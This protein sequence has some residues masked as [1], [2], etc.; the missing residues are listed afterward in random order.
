MAR[1]LI[2]VYLNSIFILR[3]LSGGLDVK[4][5]Q[6]VVLLQYSM[7]HQFNQKR[8]N[9]AVNNVLYSVHFFK[10]HNFFFFF[11]GGGGGHR[12]NISAANKSKIE[13]IL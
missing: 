3:L 5:A 11:G 2:L 12:G 4:M 1:D 7:Q 8:S 13:Q 10:L 6:Q 9:R